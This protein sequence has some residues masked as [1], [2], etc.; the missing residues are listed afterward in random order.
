MCLIFKGING[1]TDAIYVTTVLDACQPPERPT[2]CISYRSARIDSRTTVQDTCLC[3]AIEPLAYKKARFCPL[4]SS[5][6]SRS[7]AWRPP[8][9]SPGRPCSWPPTTAATSPASNS[10]STAAWPK[11]N[12]SARSNRVALV[13]WLTVTCS[14]GQP[15]APAPRACRTTSGQE[16]DLICKIWFPSLARGA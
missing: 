9:R 2:P 7:G 11:S 15:R 12:R 4:P 16:P 5:A 10:S 8:T 6:R 3:S 13:A 1:T 14:C